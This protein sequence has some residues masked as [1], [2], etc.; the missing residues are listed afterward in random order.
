[1][2]LSFLFINE[3]IDPFLDKSHGSTQIFFL[4]TMFNITERVGNKNVSM[5]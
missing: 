4:E 2:N 1:M 3:S 5:I